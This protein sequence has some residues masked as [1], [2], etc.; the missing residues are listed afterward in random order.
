MLEQQLAGDGLLPA[1][2]ATGVCSESEGRWKGGCS[3]RNIAQR[4]R[5]QGAEGGRAGAPA[6]TT[7]TPAPE[8]EASARAATTAATAPPANMYSR[9]RG[10]AAAGIENAD[11]FRLVIPGAT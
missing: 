9:V 10:I 3:K 4:G 7:A 5:R 2:C 6:H 11:K 1:S 8:S